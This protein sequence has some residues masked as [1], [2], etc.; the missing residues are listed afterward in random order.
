MGE[1]AR[2][3]SRW[4]N[5]SG[6]RREDGKDGT[7]R[8]EPDREWKERG[9]TAHCQREEE[10]EGEE[11]TG[12]MNGQHPGSERKSSFWWITPETMGVRG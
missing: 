5:L 4:P 10:E 7:I 6:Q 2:L 11:R 9:R 3:S 12:R 1:Q 8:R